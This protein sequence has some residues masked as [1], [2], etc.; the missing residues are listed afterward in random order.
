[1]PTRLA[2]MAASFTTSLT[3]PFQCRRSSTVQSPIVW[4]KYTAETVL[5][6]SF[7][8]FPHD[9]VESR[10]TLPAGLGVGSSRSDFYN[11]A[12]QVFLMARGSVFQIS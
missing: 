4:H 6:P 8:D 11:F 7:R 9:T 2:T 3:L 5:S 1:M 12:V 10:L